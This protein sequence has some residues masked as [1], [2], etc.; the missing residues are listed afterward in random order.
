MTIVVLDLKGISYADLRSVA[1]PEGEVPQSVVNWLSLN[2][3]RKNLRS[4]IEELRH[5]LNDSPQ[6]AQC[7]QKT[8]GG[9]LSATL[10]HAIIASAQFCEVC[11]QHIAMPNDVSSAIP[12]LRRSPAAPK[13]LSTIQVFAGASPVAPHATR[14]FTVGGTERHL[15]S[16]CSAAASAMPAAQAFHSGKPSGLPAATSLPQ[17]A[18]S[19]TREFIR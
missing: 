14:H 11:R 16:M 8:P 13:P 4:H 17:P 7:S 6:G 3:V 2:S 18:A 5:L 9:P 1:L 12:G 19:Y 15:P 10:C